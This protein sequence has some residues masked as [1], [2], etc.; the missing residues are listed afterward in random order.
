MSQMPMPVQ[1]GWQCPRCQRVYSPTTQMCLFCQPRQT[2][3]TPTTNPVPP[4]TWMGSG[5]L[6]GKT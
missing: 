2:I 5:S 1:Q 3:Q 4:Y 6:E